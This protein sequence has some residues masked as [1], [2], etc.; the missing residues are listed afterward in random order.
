M[1]PKQNLI[2]ITLNYAFNIIQTLLF[3]AINGYYLSLT[4]S[5]CYTC[6]EF[7]LMIFVVVASIT[8]SFTDPGIITIKSSVRHI[9]EE[10]VVPDGAIYGQ[11]YY[12]SVKKS[13][14]L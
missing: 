10:V 4:N 7:F 11:E 9:D 12:T 13:S 6:V 2:Q 14:V 5:G 8:C 1:G 3:A